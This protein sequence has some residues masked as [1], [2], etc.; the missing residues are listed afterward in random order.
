MKIKL[1]NI[2]FL[3][4]LVFSQN[5][6]HWETA[7]FDHDTW[8]YLEGTYEP[9]TN[10]RKLSFNDALWDQG[11]GGIGYGDGDDSTLI[12]PVISLYLR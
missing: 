1:L 6:D 10:W 2:V 5:I 11:Q 4:Y 9:D 7:V 12:N 8:K 3:P